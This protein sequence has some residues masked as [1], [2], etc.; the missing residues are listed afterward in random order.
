MQITLLINAKTVKEVTAIDDNVEG[1]YMSTAIREAQD[2]DLCGVLGDALVRRLQ[3][4]VD[5]G[6]I[7]QEANAHYKE[8]LDRYVSMF[9]AYGTGVRLIPMTSYKIANAGL[10]KVSDER[11][12]VADTAEQ[13][14]ISQSWVNLRNAYCRKMQAYVL[15]NRAFFPEIGTDKCYEMRANLHSSANQGIWL[16]GARGKR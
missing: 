15:E 14:R 2:I 1:K 11:I 8:L 12:T 3:D 7:A 6:T 16:G 9:L 10:D 4:L 13:G 5:D